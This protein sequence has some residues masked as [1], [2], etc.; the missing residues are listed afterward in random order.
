MALPI[1][2]RR[3]AL[4]LFKQGLRAKGVAHRL[5]IGRSTVRNWQH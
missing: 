1:E 3:Q 5:G 2:I 4:D